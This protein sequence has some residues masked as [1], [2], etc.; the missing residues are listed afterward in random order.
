M[1][2]S[3]LIKN[4]INI[5]GNGILHHLYYNLEEALGIDSQTPKPKRQNNIYGTECV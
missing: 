5:I 3:R 4:S 2:L 1:R